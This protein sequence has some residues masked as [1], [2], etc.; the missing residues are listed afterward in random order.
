M[1]R[2]FFLKS[3]NFPASQKLSPIEYHPIIRKNILKGPPSVPVLKK[4]ET[5]PS[6]SFKI[7]FINIYGPHLS[8][9]YTF[10]FPNLISK[11]PFLTSF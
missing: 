1:E 11:F 10:H 4:I 5:S 2:I 3:I 9:I 7:H 6:Y 8:Q